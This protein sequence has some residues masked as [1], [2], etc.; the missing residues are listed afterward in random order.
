MA[1]GQHSRVDRPRCGTCSPTFCESGLCADAPP[2]PGDRWPLMLV[3]TA[4]ALVSALAAAG[5]WTVIR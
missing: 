4:F 3:F 1:H 5:A 2:A